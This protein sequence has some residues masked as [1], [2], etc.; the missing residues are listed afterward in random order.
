MP[1]CGSSFGGERAS[2]ELPESHGQE[3]QPRRGEGP[4]AEGATI[5]DRQSRGAD[6][7]EAGSQVLREGLGDGE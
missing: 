3:G 4:P 2:S 7:E 5:P 6:G 1:C